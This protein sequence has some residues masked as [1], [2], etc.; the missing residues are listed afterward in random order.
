MNTFPIGVCIGLG[1]LSASL[2]PGQVQLLTDDFNDNSKNAVKWGADFNF[3]G[4]T[5]VWTETSERLQ[6]TLGTA[7]DTTRVR[8]WIL[9]NPTYAQDW[10]VI[11]KAVNTKVFASVTDGISLGIAVQNPANPSQVV[12]AE[13]YADNFG[14]PNEGFFSSFLDGGSDVGGFES[15][16]MNVSQGLLRIT[17]DKTTKVIRTYYKTTG[18]WVQMASYGISGSGG[19]ANGNRNWGLSGGSQFAIGVFAFSGG[20]TVLAGQMYADDFQLALNTLDSSVNNAPVFTS[21]PVTNAFIGAL[22]QYAASA[23]DPESNAVTFTKITG[24]AWVNV[25]SNGLASGTPQEGDAGTFTVTIRAIDNALTPAFTDQSYSLAVR[26]TFAGWQTTYFNLPAE[27]G[28]AQPGD[29][30]DGDRTPNIVEFALKT[31]PRAK[32]APP[33][34]KLSFDGAGFL[35]MTHQVRDDAP[36]LSVLA[37]FANTV[38]FADA[39]ATAGVVSD[40]LPGDGYQTLTFTDNI[41]VQSATNRFSRFKFT[42]TE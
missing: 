19:G 23:T 40:P 7:S 17:F 11:I 2:A 20:N 24:P 38:S 15:G 28:I 30:P 27:A 6:F 12:T 21:L 18:N 42:V 31:N 34:P 16:D 1:L 9:Q 33:S 41:T 25:S 37:E 5:G 26:A 29:D 39:F 4:A 3:D 10:E 36:G 22:Y 32:D 13:I 35:T 8:P 14:T